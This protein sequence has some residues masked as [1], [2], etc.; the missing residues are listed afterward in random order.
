MVI[1]VIKTFFCI[2]LLCVLTTCSQSL[3]LLSLPNKSLPFLFF[4]VPI[5]PR[6]ISLIAQIFLMKSLVFPIL[7]FS[8][9]FL[10]CSF[11]KASLSL[12]ATLWNSGF[13]WVYLSLS[14]LPFTS[15]LSSAICKAPSDSHFAFL[16]FFFFGQFWSLP[17]GQCY[18]FLSLVRQAVW[19][20]ILTP[21]NLFVTS[22]DL[23]H[24]WMA[25]WFS[26][27]PSI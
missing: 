4:M 5:L 10:H 22:P 24:I 21:F 12:L 23:Y 27:L 18:E 8:S 3:L 13:S 7:L 9:I 19:L 16:H 20:P 2:V 6:N 26:L 17:T 15:L 14:P 1:Q 11:K 25:Q